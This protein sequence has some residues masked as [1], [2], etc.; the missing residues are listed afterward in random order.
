M[1]KFEALEQANERAREL[2]VTAPRAI[3]A[4]Y[5]RESGR[6]VI[7]LSS[8]LTVSFSPRDAQGLENARPA[9]LREIEISPSGFGLHF[10]KLD[11]D[12]YVPGLLEGLLGSKEWM[13]SR[14]GQ[15][16]GQSRSRAKRA[17]AK[18]NGRLGGRPRKSA[19][20]GKVLGAKR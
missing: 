2:H 14:L 17:A 12:L 19:A 1:A 3:S 6:M 7:D 5:D 15:K 10:P 9:E 20:A 11:A 4:R 18:A 16:G 8:S 13:A